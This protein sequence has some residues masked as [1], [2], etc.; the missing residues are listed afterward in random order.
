MFHVVCCFL[1]RRA[2]DGISPVEVENSIALSV[3]SGYFPAL[4]LSPSAPT[5]QSRGF[6]WEAVLIF[7][8]C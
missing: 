1:L 2:W 6:M 3:S 5:S 8:N 4:K 7:G